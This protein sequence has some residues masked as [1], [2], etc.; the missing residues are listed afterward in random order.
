MATKCGV[1]KE[2]YLVFELGQGMVD[3]EL[4]NEIA[5][6]FGMKTSQLIVQAEER[7]SRAKGK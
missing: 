6:V 3:F 2:T 7:M 5:K 1:G 4:V